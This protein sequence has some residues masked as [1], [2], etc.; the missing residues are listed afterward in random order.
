MK[1]QRVLK[2]IVLFSVLFFMATSAFAEI[3][4]PINTKWRWR[5]GDVSTWATE[6]S[7]SS[8]LWLDADIPGYVEDS[9]KFWVR[10]TVTIPS[11]LQKENVYFETGALIGAAEIYANGVLIGRHGS[12][13]PKLNFSHVANTV[14]LIPSSTIKDNQVEIA[15]KCS[16]GSNKV[17]FSQ[18]FLVD[19]ARFQKTK[20]LQSFLNT[21]VYF[22]MSA[23][24]LFLGIYFIMQFFADKSDKSNL[25]LA[26]AL[27]FITIYFLDIASEILFLPY[28]VQI[29][30][31]RCCLVFSIGFIDLFILQN[32]K[33][34]YRIPQIIIFAVFAICAVCYAITSKDDVTHELMFSIS[35]LPIFAGIIFL[36]YTVIKA[37]RNKER[38]A[39]KILWGIS[40]GMIFGLN[41]IIYEVMGQT[42][43]AWL[44]GFSFFFV[45][46]T[47]FI[48]VSIESIQNKKR[49][50]EYIQ[51]TSAQKDKLN[52]I[53]T[54]AAKLS[55]E[56][57]E[58][59]NSLNESIVHFS[60]TAAQS[61]K[62]AGEIGSYIEKQ[63]M[64]IQ[65][66]AKALDN[67]LNSVQTVKTE[68]ATETQVVSSTV[69]ETSMMINGVK[70]VTGVI[71]KAS[72]I[73]NSLGRL[74]VKSS[75]DVSEL[76]HIMELI[77][78]SS[79]EILGVVQVVTDFANR[80][81][82]LA[83]NASIEAAHSGIQ[84]KGFSVIAHEIKKLASASTSQA[85]KI[86]DIV[87]T[88]N[89]NIMQSFDLTL[90]VRKTLGE[91]SKNAETT[92]EKV[93]DSAAQMEKQY[94]AGQKISEA[95]DLMS[96][97]AKNVQNE[98]NQQYLF[99]KEVSENME[100]L[101]NA[102]AEAENAVEGIITKN[103]ILSEQTSSLQDLA[104]RAKEA[105][106]GLNALMNE[107]E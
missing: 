34:K 89:D 96:K 3:M 36:F 67:L 42:P 86:R 58:I 17:K 98:A 83:M 104:R 66:T 6:N 85:E 81:N 35:L 1:S 93:S 39:R 59:A 103:K 45:D 82:M 57:T 91:V 84:G 41:D 14:C 80:T 23:I 26:L 40:I 49:I 9:G 65:N 53:I 51:T 107:N 73:A 4:E 76:V 61:A 70:S 54:K 12:I 63:N 18:F 10:G 64:S 22:M 24:C 29:S 33:K 38:N 43:F 95:T 48:V 56:T 101:S 79:A 106:E 5:T 7:S 90:S 72:D 30:I 78:D 44:Q 25:S 13:E 105:T 32:F 55:S 11:S 75:D 27:I 8:S 47:M 21:T 31:S 69:D 19:S 87:T 60:N 77:K 52:S 28:L 94:E 62:E 37:V 100:K 50:T 15:I 68:I 102:A 99:S 16:S 92:S 46:I 20:Y 71:N 97:S 74:A 88:I 2:N